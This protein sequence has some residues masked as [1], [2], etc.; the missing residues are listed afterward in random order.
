MCGVILHQHT[1]LVRI[2]SQ[3]GPRSGLHRTTR[4]PASRYK[5]YVGTA[6]ILT[7]YSVCLTRLLNPVHF[8][9]NEEDELKRWKNLMDKTIAHLSTKR[10]V[11]LRNDRTQLAK[12]ILVVIDGLVKRL[13]LRRPAKVFIE[14]ARSG[15]GCYKCMFLY[16]RE[17][18]RL[19]RERPVHS[20]QS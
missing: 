10:S 16:L 7:C 4:V 5:L 9:G 12:N 17:T 13:R 3:L 2:L 11:W 18:G 15:T 1:H 20:H 6:C 8:E 19:A 14:C